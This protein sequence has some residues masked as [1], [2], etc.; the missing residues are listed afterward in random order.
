MDIG[1]TEALVRTNFRGTHYYESAESPEDYLKHTHHHTF[2]V[3]VRVEEYHNDRDIEY[4]ALL[5]MV[6][7][8]IDSLDEE[9]EVKQLGK[10]SCEDVA[11]YILKRLYKFIDTS[12]EVEI[13]VLEDG[14][15][16]ATIYRRNSTK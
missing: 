5:S 1:K 9:N 10:M 15:C 11:D 13:S 14:L 12:R 8:I 4:H 16:G 7:S 6:D 2:M 3:E